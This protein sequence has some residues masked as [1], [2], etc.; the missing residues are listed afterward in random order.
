MRRPFDRNGRNVDTARCAT[1]ENAPLAVKRAT[2]ARKMPISL[3]R[4][5][6]MKADA[7]TESAV[8]AVLDKVA[9]AYARRDLA[10]LLAAFAPDPDVVMYGTGAD[11]KRVGLAQIQTQVERDWSQAEAAAVTYESISVSAAGAVAWA[12]APRSSE[13]SS[14]ER[15]L[16]SQAAFPE[17]YEQTLVGPLFRPWVESLLEDVGLGRG[18]RVL[19]I[20]CGTGIV[21]RLAQERLGATGRVVA[22]DMNPRML[23][24]ARS[25]APGID[26]R[27][28]DAAALPLH[29][30]D[31]F[32]VVL[33]QQGFQFFRDPAAAA[34][35]MRRALGKN[36]RL[37][38]STWRSDEES[39]LLR[40]LR[41]VA[42]R[43]VGPIA[44]R[45]HSL[46]EP[47]PIEALLRD[48]GFRNVRSK[49]V[50]RTIRFADGAAFVHL[51]AMALVGMSPA[52]GS[53]D[54]EA[55][56][57]V[58]ASIARDSADLVR[59]HTDGRGFSYEIG[60]NVVL[61]GA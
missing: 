48:A 13:P 59:L 12:M 55:R 61:A 8:K 56:Q 5:R 30:T 37:G 10:L 14:G 50:S 29:A 39:P 1:I 52:S 18:D 53:L 51:N 28:G 40:R 54:D 20:A 25:V 7:T 49:R 4:R 42:E 9:D 6:P 35:E 17:T 41:D 32:D 11:E 31:Q 3:K 44:D 24:V 58:V 38:L 22:V 23:A 21:A 46:S 36:G 57:R 45:R 16:V 27:E 19:D 60:A 26:W 33:C 47:G 34:R 15:H 43:H 2:E